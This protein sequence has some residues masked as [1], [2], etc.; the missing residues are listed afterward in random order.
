MPDDAPTGFSMMAKWL[1]NVQC[2]TDTGVCIH[3]EWVLARQPP[4]APVRRML[5]EATTRSRVESAS[6]ATEQHVLQQGGASEGRGSWGQR[7]E[8]RA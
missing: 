4:G 6:T 7:H 1:G 3:K 8:R 2:N 5:R